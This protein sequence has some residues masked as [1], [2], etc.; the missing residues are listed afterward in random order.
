MLSVKYIPEFNWFLLVEQDEAGVLSSAR[1]NLIRSLLIGLAASLIILFISIFTVNHFQS[2]LE[3]IA[4]TDELT[5]VANRREF[6][7]QFER[8]LHRNE[9][10]SIDFSLVMIDID[11]LKLVNDKLGHL[12]GDMLI[13]NVANVILKTVRTNDV[14][15]RWGGDEFIVLVEGELAQARSAAERI[16]AAV[17][18]ENL[19]QQ[20]NLDWCD[21][22]VTV[23]CGISQYRTD[24]TLDVATA[25]AD[26]AMYAIKKSG[27]NGVGYC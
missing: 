25:R 5:G 14:V 26:Q 21:P 8:A 4:A 23:S 1:G 20:E 22:K 27:K 11:G 10:Y 6:A 13:K 7:A 2:R 18:A 17:E 9:R 24:D 12:S 3:Y 16:R 19:P 15:A